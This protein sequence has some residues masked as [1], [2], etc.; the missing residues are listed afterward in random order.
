MGTLQE[1]KNPATAAVLK[2]LSLISAV[3]RNTAK[4]EVVKLMR[5]VDPELIRE[6]DQN[7]NGKRHEWVMKDTPHVGTVV[8][9]NAGQPVAYYVPRTI[10][11]ALNG[12]DPMESQLGL[13]AIKANNTLKA[14]YTQLNYGFWPVNLMRDTG[15]FW[16]QMPGAMS[17]LR[18][19]KNLP[20][21][22]RAA[23]SSTKG[24]PNA[25]AVDALK[26][27]MVISRAEYRGLDAADEH[28][29]TLESFGQT[30]ADW[31]RTAKQH[32]LLMRAWLKY[33]GFGQTFE[34]LNKING[35]L[36]LDEHFPDKP[37][38]QKRKIVRE[39]A[40]SPDFLERSG[41]AVVNWA[42][43]FY[44][45]WKEGLH[46]LKAAAKADPWGFSFKTFAMVMLPAV[47]Q[48]LAASG[49]FG[50]ERQKQY[51]SI[52]DYDLSNYWCIP[53]GWQNEAQG[54]VA[55]L[56]LPLAEPMRVLN[57]VVFHSLTDRGQG[58]AEYGAGQ[59]PGLNSLAKVAMG[60]G[61]LLLA[62][63]NPP[64]PLRGKD[65]IEPDVFEAGGLP[66]AQ[67]MG[68]WT[69]NELGGG[70]VHR[71]RDP[72]LTDAPQENVEKFL[73][74]PV[75]SNFLGR[76]V[77]VSSRGIDDQ[78]RKLAEPVRQQRAQARVA[79]REMIRKFEAQE[80]W[81]PEE[82]ALVNRDAY[83]AQYLS[84]TLAKVMAQRESLLLRR[85]EKRESSAE[86]GAVFAPSN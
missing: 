82:R 15:S 78:D 31:D 65:V 4:R 19:A 11:E 8:V 20:R 73:Q 18:W 14:L 42:L 41:S 56:R 40:G 86:R 5:E 47:L 37:E 10:A 23:V 75:V 84:E 57:G 59:L 27:L 44:N 83:A 26:R 80:P 53:L 3:H 79:V 71:F 46:S 39:L 55:Y 48:A 74:T 38:W 61:T 70:I 28:E 85:W 60:W 54:K 69:W 34:R 16:L 77:K 22:Y 2:G 29:L 50:D 30:P 62:G 45:P 81:G 51:R 43:M 36:Y 72:Q 9:M 12:A 32:H 1:I 76:W 49:L 58:L 21:A 33:K 52:P 63:K 64:D 25:D 7:W 67:A 13:A 66:V 24:T 17:P 35:M 68:K 6:A